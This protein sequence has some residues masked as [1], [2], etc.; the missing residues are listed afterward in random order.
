MGTTVRVLSN[1]SLFTLA[2]AV[3]FAFGAVAAAFGAGLS[4]APLP[5]NLASVA[6]LFS[7]FCPLALDP[8]VIQAHASNPRVLDV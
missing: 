5:P 4:L 1:L 6:S 2:F 8:F 3:A 7:S